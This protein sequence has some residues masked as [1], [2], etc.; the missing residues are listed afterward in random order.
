M[1]AGKTHSGVTYYQ[2]TPRKCRNDQVEAKRTSHRP[3]L[4]SV[5]FLHVHHQLPEICA[6]DTQRYSGTNSFIDLANNLFLLLRL[7]FEIG[8][9][10]MNALVIRNRLVMLIKTSSRMLLSIEA[11]NLPREGSSPWNRNWC[12]SRSLDYP[13]LTKFTIR[14]KMFRVVQPSPSKIN[15]S[16]SMEY[17]L[18]T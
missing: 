13:W 15:I 4:E 12:R 7:L 5:S 6:K 2:V 14:V 16:S 10:T 18:R 1:I 8:I 9:K 3:I 11:P 17:L